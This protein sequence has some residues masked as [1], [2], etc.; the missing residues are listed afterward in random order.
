MK[1]INKIITI[2]ITILILQVVLPI[3]NVVFESEFTLISKAEYIESF[4]KKYVMSLSEQEFDAF[5]EEKIMIARKYNE[6]AIRLIKSLLPDY[7]ELFNNYEIYNIFNQ[8]GGITLN[9]YD[10]QNPNLSKEKRAYSSGGKITINCFENELENDS[11]WDGLRWLL[12]HEIMHSL[13]EF[14]NTYNTISNSKVSVKVRN[15]LLEEGL[16]DSIAYFVRKKDNYN[17]FGVIKEE[18]FKMYS[19]NIYGQVDFNSEITHT[20]T[21]SGN[22][23]NLFKYIGC[24]NELIR[25]NMDSDFEQLRKAM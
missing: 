22:I 23:I 11:N 24:Y 4:S 7:K 14:P 2:V 21:F 3:F 18:E 19:L 17:R 5:L 25:A 1:K 8:V 6:Y 10:P 13:G 12:T 9:P 16:A 15:R 20:Y